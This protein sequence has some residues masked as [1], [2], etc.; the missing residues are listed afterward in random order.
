MSLVSRIKLLQCENDSSEDDSSSSDDSEAKTKKQKTEDS[1][2]PKKEENTKLKEPP[3]KKK[4]FKDWREMFTKRCVG[5]K[6]EAA[7][8]RYFERKAARAGLSVQ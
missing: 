8:E 3:L 7:K 2:A 1:P 4:I 6:F 5:D